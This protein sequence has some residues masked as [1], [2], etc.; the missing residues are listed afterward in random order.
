M[1]ISAH[2]PAEPAAI[3]RALQQLWRGEGEASTIVCARTV[4]LVVCCSDAHD[5]EALGRELEPVTARH[6]GRV[7]LVAGAPGANLPD[8]SV[9]AS[10]VSSHLGDQYLGQE[11]IVLRRGQATCEQLASIVNSLF[12]PDLPV[13]LWWRDVRRLG[14][15]LFAEV[16]PRASRIIVDSATSSDPEE[17]FRAL[18]DAIGRYPDSA[19][20]DMAWTRVTPWRHLAAQFFDPPAL[21]PCLRTLRRVGIDYVARGRD[22]TYVR[23]EALLFGAWLAVSL[24]HSPDWSAPQDAPSFR[25]LRLSGGP[26]P[27]DLELKMV[28]GA[29]EWIQQVQLESDGGTFRMARTAQGHAFLT[30]ALVPGQPPVQRTVRAVERGSAESL[31]RELDFEQ[32]D[33]LYERVLEMACAFAR[34]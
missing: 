25:R 14:S 32:R 1:A 26:V 13:F 24:G 6:P 11:M 17:S 34:R 16:A 15:D 21:A 20:T 31:T 5:L 10:C 19:I 22:Q 30:V 4:N 29:E 18:R 28:D 27:L 9:S 3:E 8:A 2:I 23:P 12:L 33:Q 7:I